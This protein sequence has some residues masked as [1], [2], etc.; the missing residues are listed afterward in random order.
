VYYGTRDRI[1]R[2]IADRRGIHVPSLVA[3]SRTEVVDVQAEEAA[4]PE[5]DVAEIE[6]A[7]TSERVAP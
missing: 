5:V 4:I 3:D 6:A 2:A 7:M 1:L